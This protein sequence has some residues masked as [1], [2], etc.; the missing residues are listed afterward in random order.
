M[1]KTAM[2]EIEI[3]VD[4]L[5]NKHCMHTENIGDREPRNLCQ[6]GYG[7]MCPL[8]SVVLKKNH[9]GYFIRC[10]ACIDTFGE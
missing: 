8:F 3:D 2:V 4:D 9:R 6:W 5:K 10:Q 1:I 7:D